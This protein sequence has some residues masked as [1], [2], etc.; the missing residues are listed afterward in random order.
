MFLEIPSSSTGIV[1]L[2]VTI[3]LIIDVAAFIGNLLVCV[4]SYRN[5]RLRTATNVYVISLAITD[6]LA[7]CITAPLS[8]GAIISRQWVFGKIGCQIQ[9]FFTHFLIYSSMY[10]LSLTAVNRY[11]RIVKPQF[12]KKFF[13]GKRSVG[14]LAVMWMFVALFVSI[15]P[16]FGLADFKFQPGVSLYMCILDFKSSAGDVTFLF[17][18]LFFFVILSMTI[19]VASYIQVFRAIRHHKKNVQTSLNIPKRFGTVSLEEIKITRTLFILV[20][21][22]AICWIPVYS[23]VSI[24]RTGLGGSMTNTGSIVATYL[25]FLSSAINPYVYA[26]NHRIYRVE[27]KRILSC[28]KHHTIVPDIG[29]P[30]GPR[31]VNIG[32]GRASFGYRAN[33]LVSPTVFHHQLA[34]SQIKNRGLER[35]LVHLKDQEHLAAVVNKEPDV[36][37]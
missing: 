16:L 9:G 17:L 28:K 18:V 37:T 24:I 2:E 27:F 22:F 7:A 26:F 31:N 29:N 33:N 20:M 13:G 36:L 4:A 8:L 21:A 30:Q 12:Y 23:V 19:I 1:I 14:I 35:A 3:L 25:I 15:P 11:F 34:F 6:I 10:T 32:R 5:H